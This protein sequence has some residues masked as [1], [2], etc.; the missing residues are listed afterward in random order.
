MC[1]GF[2]IAGAVF[3]L[4]LLG[5]AFFAAGTRPQKA[6][7]DA[8]AVPRLINYQGKLTD[9]ATGNPVPDG[10]YD[11]TFAIYD[12]A[13]GGT[14]QWTETQ[15]AVQLKN[16]LFNVKLGA[17]APITDVPAGGN[18]WLQVTVGTTPI[19]PRIQLTST[20]Y[21]YNAQKADDADKLGGLHAS[22][23][24]PWTTES[25]DIPH[26]VWWVPPFGPGNK[27]VIVYSQVPANPPYNLYA[28]TWGTTQYGVFGQNTWQGGYGVSGVNNAANSYAVSGFN[29]SAGTSSYAVY[30][31]NTSI[32][33]HAV[34]GYD[35]YSGD[36]GILGPAYTML[37][38]YIGVYGYSPK[39]NGYGVY[40][41]GSGS[42]AYGVYG[43]G[44]GSL[45][46]GVYGYSPDAISVYGY[47]G[48]GSY[49][50]YFLNSGGSGGIYARGFYYGGYFYNQN[51]G[52]NAYVAYYTYKIY[53]TGSV[54]TYI[55]DA[56]DQERTLHCPET[57]EVLFEDVGSNHLTDGYCKVSIDPLLLR[58][59]VIDAE[60][61]LRVFVTPKGR[62]PVAMSV[63]NGDS[64]F[65]VYGPTGSNTPFDWRLVANRKGFQNMRFEPHERAADQKGKA[66]KMP[67]DIYPNL[68]KTPYTQ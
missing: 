22:E 35:S 63:E 40:G 21:A 50:G 31:Y 18:C 10:S 66:V 42:P 17:V 65:E 38:Q 4:L 34:Y 12:T 29:W 43:Y 11:L 9:P 23:V 51:S 67:V 61:P 39:N 54:S 64:Y 46:C 60:N 5:G 37:S 59:I 33:G 15:T 36:V 68:K 47:T 20:P 41:Y 8:I 26:I 3:C 19:A 56:N 32:S 52:Y 16:G 1:K 44:S 53:G 49:A 13:T 14:P 24:G 55:I 58:G 45:G 6:G 7:T 57:P 62:E 25:T 2:K 28:R 48:T 30:G 27:G